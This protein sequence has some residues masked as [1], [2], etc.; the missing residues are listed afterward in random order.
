M[1]LRDCIV[2]KNTCVAS[3]YYRMVVEIPEE[4]LVSKP[5]QFFMLKSLQ[6]AFSLRRPISIHQVNKQDR[7]ME[8]YYEVKGRGTDSLADFQEGEK[9]SLQGPL[10]HGFSVVKDKKVIV[11][12]GGMGIAP[13]K[14]LLDDLKENN[15]VTFIAGGRNQDAIEILDFFSF[16]KL[17]AYITTDDGSVGMKGNVVTK[18]K[19][20][21]EQDS[22]DQIYVCGPHGMMIAA[23]ET[24]QE[25]GVAC[26]ISL[27]N[28]MACGVKACVGCSI[29]TVDGLRKVCHDGPVFDSRKIVNYDPKEKASICCG[30]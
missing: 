14:Y 21:L 24:A 1:Y 7:T 6:D 16:Q 19:D 25:K 13:M 10:G 26:E 23:A 9:I 27:E 15:E 2:K 30:N 29:Q 17:R 28:R 4:L 11:I 3:C 12:G 22:Y 18:L 5:G 20:L 8:F